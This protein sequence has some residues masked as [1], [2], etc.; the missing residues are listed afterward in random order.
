MKKIIITTLL[1][2]L[3]IP[4]MAQKDVQIEL[5]QKDLQK[6]KKEK[7]YAE[8]KFE[9]TNHNF[10]TFAAD[11]AVLDCEFKFKN[12]GNA[13]L[14]IHQAF[15]SCGCTVPDFPI[16]PIK[17]GESGVIKITY[18]GTHKAPGNMRRSISIHTNGKQEIIKLYISGKMLPRK[19]KETP[20]INIDEN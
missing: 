8:I 14:Y 17:P 3:L 11:T 20:I 9:K 13:D 4:A 7:S 1:A 10:G 15:A 5:Q 12:I 2:M 6:G 18:D 19:I 16:A